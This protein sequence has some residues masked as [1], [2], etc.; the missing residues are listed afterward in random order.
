M[1]DSWDKIRDLSSGLKGL[2]VI[3]TT[4]IAGSAISALFWFYMATILGAENYGQISYF[5]SIGSIVSTV[6]LLGSNNM[7]SVYIPKDVRLESTVFLLS[8]IA[9]LVAVSTLFFVFSDI[10]VSTYVIGMVFV[11][12]AGSEILAKKQ[13]RSY[14]KYLFT[15]KILMVGLAI[16]L[17]HV[18]G[19]N[20]VIIGLG[21]AFFPYLIRIYKGFRESKI[22]F[23]LL[24]SRTG[25]MFNS[26]ILNLSSAFKGSID[27]L[28][29]APLVGFAL[30]GNYQLG[31]QFLA[32]IN[33][34]A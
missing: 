19:V 28:I 24:K 16:G 30:L 15:S 5:L 29:I 2:T 3:G 10:S 12:L 25:F 31:I 18:I 8:I 4:D 7:L 22:D 20:G 13:Y 23:S 21:L 32:V 27:K 34:N 6:S 26:F 33:M 14:S 1:T 11:G 9:G 17:Y